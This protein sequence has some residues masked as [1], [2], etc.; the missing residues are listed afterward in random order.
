MMH[1]SGFYGYRPRNARYTWPLLTPSGMV[2]TLTTGYVCTICD[3][4]VLPEIGKIKMCNCPNTVMWHY[5]NWHMREYV[6]CLPRHEYVAQTK[7][8]LEFQG[9]TN[10]HSPNSRRTPDLA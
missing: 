8:L 9:P 7:L 4:V 5:N 10:V 1:V 6:D 3:K 2:H